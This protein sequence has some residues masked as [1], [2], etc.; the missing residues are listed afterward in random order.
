M[1]NRLM[2]TSSV[3]GALF[4]ALM[5]YM[6]G[7]SADA[8]HGTVTGNVTFD[9]EP[10]KSGTIRFDPVDGQTATADGV[11]SDGRFSAKAPP[12]EKRVSISAQ[13]VVGKKKMYDT[14]ESPVVDV[15]E[16]LLPK[17]YNAQS[18]LTLKVEAG[19]Q[20]HNFDLKSG[21]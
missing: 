15:T 9:G 12:G 17:R 6:V 16:E 19:S 14:P 1:I 20:E 8:K 11:I 4:V 2:K 10:V 13:K 18:E 5:Y 21:K 7:C 3:V